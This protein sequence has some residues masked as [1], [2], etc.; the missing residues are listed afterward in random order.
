[1]TLQVYT[2]YL[3]GPSDLCLVIFG[4]DKLIRAVELSLPS[5]DF[6]RFFAATAAML[7]ALIFCSSEDIFFVMAYLNSKSPLFSSVNEALLRALII[8]GPKLMSLTGEM[9]GCAKTA[10][11]LIRMG[12]LAITSPCS[13]T[14]ASMT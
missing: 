3:S 9:S 13:P 14:W 7:I 6:V 8:M 11:A 10:L 4:L 5:R 1:M 12:M 2:L